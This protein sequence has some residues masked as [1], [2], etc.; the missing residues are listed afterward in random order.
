M[1]DFQEENKMKQRKSAFWL[2]LIILIPLVATVTMIEL[3]KASPT[4]VYFDYHGKSEIYDIMM[5]P[6]NRFTI[7]ITV[8]YIHE[9]W[10]YQ[11]L[12]F[13]N[14]EVLHGVSVEN[15][16]FL[17]SAG[18][19][20][21]EFPGFGFDNTK[22]VLYLFIATIYPIR[23]PFPTGGG[24]LASIT[25]EIVGTGGSPLT[26]GAETGL[27][28]KTGGYLF[29]T[30]WC[31]G[32]YPSGDRGAM[33]PYQPWLDILSEGSG[34]FD[35]RPPAYVD[36]PSVKD[37]PINDSFTVNVDVADMEDLY[38]WDFFMSWD[39]ILLNV[40]SVTEGDFLKEQPE[41]TSFFSEIHNEEG[42]TYAN[43]STVGSHPGVNGNGT[44]ATITFVVKDIGACDLTLYDT[45]LLDS[46][47]IQINSRVANGRFTNQKFH[48][49]DITD[50][51]PHPERVE[52]GSNET[53]SIDVTVE[54]SGDFDETNIKV[55]TYYGENEIGNETIPSLS[56]GDSTTLTF[57]LNT[58]GVPRGRYV[59]SARAEAEAAED[60]YTYG[61]LIIS[62]HDITI[63]SVTIPVM[64][65]YQGTNA[66]IYVNIK[67]KGTELENFT[68]TA[69]YNMNV[70][71]TVNLYN[72]GY[73]D[74][75]RL[76][77]EWD[78]AGVALGNYTVSANA[79]VVEGE[80]NTADNSFVKSGTIN[81]IPFEI[82]PFPT[83]LF[84]LVAV[85]VV[86][87]SA[88]A[89]YYVWRK[90]KPLEFPE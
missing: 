63:T 9:L 27:L 42:Y 41:G 33:E 15:G 7:N 12:M 54:N 29:D 71:A 26:L 75:L 72:F 16:P 6:P 17:E 25:F 59:L 50:V 3:V 4:K 40:T 89:V 53:I 11:F 87:I 58:T 49:I 13:F 84:I 38:R 57:I 70:I 52:E 19:H 48:G 32:L 35:N 20:V 44:L 62:A 51:T 47:L 77:F 28:N 90:R 10:G 39:P 18:G 45:Y 5:V 73:D 30:D 82:E 55:A 21:T 86:I 74:S 34:Y 88:T 22:G 83:E 81:V 67:N 65:V 2:I 68:I 31:Y 85:P 78:T 43:C 37:V 64:R 8:D 79:T 36:P 14:P 56:V 24:T 23:P 76:T 66:T 80:E 69:Y 46:A 1:L 60:L 61:I